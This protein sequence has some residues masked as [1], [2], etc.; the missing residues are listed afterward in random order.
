MFRPG[1]LP[2]GAADMMA[3]Q[4]EGW[5]SSGSCSCVELL[6]G[7]ECDV[8]AKHNGERYAFGRI[9]ELPFSGCTR[10]PCCAC[11]FLPV[12]V[13]KKEKMVVWKKTL[14][15]IG[16]VWAAAVVASLILGGCAT[17]KP[18]SPAWV[19]C[20]GARCDELWSRVQVWVAK[21]SSYRIQIT[22]ENILQTYGP[23]SGIASPAYTV[24]RERQGSGA[25]III[26]AICFDSGMGCMYDPSP[27]ANALLAELKRP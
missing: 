22:N 24:T 23:T 18:I 5:K 8:A 1:Q 26:H 27:Y 15:W 19:A 25:K 17:Y 16:G 12:I 14:I 3:R 6:A 7:P 9:P 13:E 11:D 10:H 4:I 21:N 2:D 20:D